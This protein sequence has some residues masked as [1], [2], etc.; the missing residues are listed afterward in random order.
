MMAIALAALAPHAAWAG[1]ALPPTDRIIIKW[2]DPSGITDSSAHSWRRLSARTDAPMTQGRR[3]GGGMQVL[4]VVGLRGSVEM[5]RVLA[6]LRADPAV[7]FA[8]PDRRVKIQVTTPS[9]PLFGSGQW[10]LKSAEASATRAHNAWDITRGGDSAATSPV[11]VA[12]IDTGVRPDHPELA[13]KLLP[14]YDFVSGSTTDAFAVANDGDSWDPDPSDPGDFLTAADLASSTFSSG[15][16]GGGPNHDIPVN[17]SWHGTRVAGMIGASTD[18][19]VGIAGIGF[20]VRILPVRV[21]G[22]CGGFESDVLAGMYWAAG[23]VL[24][25]PLLL[26]TDLPVNTHPAQV[27]NM[28]LGSAGACS[29]A[30]ATAVRDITAHGVLVVASAGNDGTAVGTPASCAGALGVAGVRHIGTK[31]GYSNLGPE[32]G[33]AAPA[34]NCVNT[35]PNEPCLFSLDTLT[36][37]G[38]NAPGA[39]IYT[40]LIDRPNFGTSFASPLVA[41]T[42]GLMKAVNPALT[43]AL[44]VA[45]IR[46]SARTFPTGSDTVPAPLA[47]Q[48][49]S[50]VALQNS[51]CICT[52]QVCGAGLLNTEGA[53][54]DAQRPAVLVGIGG[55]IAAGRTVTL[56]GS[57]SGVAMGRSVATYLWTVTSTTSST[58]PVIQDAGLATATV[59]LP[60]AGT[61][62]FRLTVTDSLGDTDLAEVSASVAGVGGG[63]GST[64]PPPSTGSG[65]GGRLDLL[66]LAT[67]LWSAAWQVRRRVR[68]VTRSRI[69]HR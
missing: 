33:I 8:E 28:S 46:S 68:S 69:A 52:T 54:I 48:L 37:D 41:G 56:D 9:D 26:R 60:N 40:D 63:G 24:P 53:V 39:N 13:D 55:T 35:G 57:R 29:A 62:V 49:P 67:A 7:E 59:V 43:P 2:H 23:L 12:V 5:E 50:V 1:A 61:T 18:N 22:K 66:L 4:H 58:T 47:C 17:S 20:N 10:Y 31:V 65:G 36:N 21:L 27:L 14:G 19:A 45:R 38:A 11:V 44:L 32:V 25:P 64:S 51:E 15:E 34:G 3:I 42:A 6:A 16:C 30:Y